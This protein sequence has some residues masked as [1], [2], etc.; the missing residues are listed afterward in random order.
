MKKSEAP[1]GWSN[2]HRPIAWR[3]RL[4]TETG[5]MNGDHAVA[6]YT[7]GMFA[8]WASD[9]MSLDEAREFVA[10]PSSSIWEPRPQ[11]QLVILQLTEVEQ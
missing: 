5:S 8:Q 7:H 10:N 11:D 9:P 6:L 2:D 1:S 4:D 3:D